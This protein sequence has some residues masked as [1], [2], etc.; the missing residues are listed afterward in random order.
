M[1]NKIKKK[2]G[3]SI[4][5]VLVVTTTILLF[6]ATAITSVMYTSK[7]NNIQVKEDDLFYIAEAGFEHGYANLMKNARETSYRKIINNKDV[8][9]EI[10]QE[11]DKLYRIR[12]EAYDNG[13]SRIVQGIIEDK[14]GGTAVN[15]NYADLIEKYTVNSKTTRI[16]IN[17]SANLLY[18]NSA[19]EMV[20]VNNI[21]VGLF[22]QPAAKPEDKIFPIPKLKLKHTNNLEFNSMREFIEFGLGKAD[23]VSNNSVIT[24]EI[25][26]TNNGSARYKVVF[27]NAD[28]IEV[29]V[30]ELGEVMQKIIIITPGKFTLNSIRTGA[31]YGYTSIICKDFEISNKSEGA[32]NI[33]PPP[34]FFYEANKEALNALI[35]KYLDDT[36]TGGGGI[37]SWEIKEMSY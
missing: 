6:S 25:D 22:P 35:N 19:T 36:P 12:S 13:K 1:V 26:F 23:N 14:R 29:N 33:N 28:N 27:A 21:Q 11:T 32:I 2:K 9:I 3:S 15:A 16:G 10:K 4:L 37:E 18:V 31:T 17:G 5:M 34:Y 30:P 7:G 8:N 24:E 20:V